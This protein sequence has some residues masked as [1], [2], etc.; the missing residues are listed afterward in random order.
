M[1]NTRS[2]MPDV[3]KMTSD[4][5]KSTAEPWRHYEKLRVSESSR[6]RVGG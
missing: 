6:L 5:T 4:V 1:K 2:E 3:M